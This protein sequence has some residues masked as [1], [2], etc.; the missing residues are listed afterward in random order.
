MGCDI[1]IAIEQKVGD[2][3]VM[4]NRAVS[5]NNAK[6]RNYERFC[7]LAG[8][9]CYGTDSGYEPTGI[10]LDVSDSTKLFIDEWGEDGHSHSCFSLSK[11]IETINK[12]DIKFGAMS[13]GETGLPWKYLNLDPKENEEYRVVFW[14]DN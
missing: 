11:F 9:R 4:V 8:V 7:A 5:T 13:E 10:P 12:I 14:F 6:K 2:K 1:H 3:W